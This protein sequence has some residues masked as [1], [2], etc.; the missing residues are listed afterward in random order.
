MAALVVSK[1]VII[2][3]L[4]NSLGATIFQFSDA[5][6]TKTVDL[7]VVGD[8][9]NGWDD[10]KEFFLGLVTL[11]NVAGDGTLYNNNSM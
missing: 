5:K 11:V 1:M 9:V 10:L 8:L 6:K 3:P 4:L 7:E 2:L